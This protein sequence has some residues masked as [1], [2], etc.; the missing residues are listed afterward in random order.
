MATYTLQILHASDFEAGLNAVNRAGNFAAIVDYLEETQTNSITLSSGDNYLPSPFFNAG[1]DPSMEE[2][3]ETAFEDFYNLA[4]GTLN[5]APSV[6]RADIA[7]LNILGVQASAIGNHEYDAG[8]REVQNIIGRTNSITGSAA[9]WI[10]T[11]FPYLSANT[12]FAGDANLSPIFTATVQN[13]SFYN[14]SPTAVASGTATN[15]NNNADRIAPATIIEENG[16]RRRPAASRSSATMWTTCHSSPPFCSPPST[17]WSR[18]AS[19]S[20][21]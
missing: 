16:R 19:I 3:Y 1:G 7:I 9:G 11:Q 10:G 21:S 18:R 15:V 12:N 17:R 6:G 20:S 2:V 4:P 8:T 13:A 14:L 5:L